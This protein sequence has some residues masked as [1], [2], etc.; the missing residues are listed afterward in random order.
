MQYSHPIRININPAKSYSIYS[1]TLGHL[2]KENKETEKKGTESKKTHFNKYLEVRN[3]HNLIDKNEFCPQVC[4][5][6][7]ITSILIIPGCIKRY[8]AF[9]GY[10]H[11]SELILL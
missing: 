11:G 1:N 2:C 8:P 4:P 9:A 6:S 7:C 5:P 3:I 10:L